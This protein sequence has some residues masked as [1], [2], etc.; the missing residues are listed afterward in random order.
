MRKAIILSK[1][2]E[3]EES[4]ILVSDNIPEDF[5]EFG[6]IEGWHLQKDTIYD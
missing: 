4:I 2:S 1:I 5:E 3:I 6:L